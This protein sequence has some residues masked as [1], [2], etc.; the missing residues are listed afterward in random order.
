MYYISFG[1]IEKYQSILFMFDVPYKIKKPINYSS[2]K[3]INITYS[4]DS[5]YDLY[6][7]VSITSLMENSINKTIWYNIYILVLPNFSPIA[8]QRLIGLARKYDRLSINII[9]VYNNFK[10][11]KR[12]GTKILRLNLPNLLPEIDR[13]IHLDVDTYIFR[14]L[15]QLY[16]LDMTNLMLRGI[17]DYDFFREM[18]KFGITNE[19]HYINS[20]VMLLNLDE[21]RKGNFVN[22]I[23]KF[24]D[25]NGS[26]LILNDQPIINILFSKK[27]GLLPLQFGFHNW[28]C[29]EKSYQNFF[30]ASYFYKYPLLPRM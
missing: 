2:Y 30:R 13:I 8:K 7:I 23:T 28:Y 14:D 12:P 18:K 10:N 6:T 19:S 1:F 11:F 3:F 16:D 17:L 20:G 26:C 29:S 5:K 27:I 9:V 15:D 25:Q 4:T 24:I 21:M 22:I